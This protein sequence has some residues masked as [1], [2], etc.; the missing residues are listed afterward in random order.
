M[1]TVWRCRVCEGVNRGGRTCDTCGATVAPRE[2]L[3]TAVRTR[4][5]NATRHAPPPVPAT[6]R[7]RELRQ[8]P[9]PEEMSLMDPYDLFTAPDGIEIR[10]MPGGCLVS[11]GPR[12]NRPTRRTRVRPTGAPPEIPRASTGRTSSS[13]SPASS[14]DRNVLRLPA[15]GSLGAIPQLAQLVEAAQD[16]GALPVRVLEGRG[17]GR[18]WERG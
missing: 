12:R 9:S 1:S 3:R 7:R 5:P 6:P 10:P 4:L 15:D 18:I 14:S 8:L 11:I 16:R 2:A 13:R 17:Q